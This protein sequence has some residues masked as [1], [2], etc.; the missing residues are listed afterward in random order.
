MRTVL[1][2]LLALLWVSVVFVGTLWL[3]F[4]SDTFAERLRYEVPNTLGPEYSAD[5]KSVAPWWV[6]LSA[7]DLKIYHTAR[8]GEEEAGAVLVALVRDARARVSVWSLLRR[9][10]YLSGSVTLTEGT[11][12]YE[13]GTAADDKGRVALSDLVLS[14][15]ALPVSDLLGL[16]GM[17]D[18]RVDGALQLDVDLHAGADGMKD[19]TGS[20]KLGG[21][22]LVIADFEIPGM[23]NLGMEIPVQELVLMAE[24]KDGKATLQHGAFKSDL[25]TAALTGDVTLRD[26]IERSSID[27]EISITE[28]GDQLKAFEGFLSD[29]KQS[30]GTF[31]YACRGVI[32]R[33]GP[34]SCTA[35]RARGVSSRIPSTDRPTAIPRSPTGVPG[36]AVETDEERERRRE[37]IRERLRQ[38]RE[39]REGG[40]TREVAPTRVDPEPEEDLPEDDEEFLH[41]EEEDLAPEDDPFVEDLEQ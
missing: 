33:L 31:K 23:G 36:G 25:L 4:P 14:A 8:G 40:G 17:G 2:G 3:T 6:G 22:N 32:S 29:A 19:A 9:A 30:D 41:D 16:A 13:V 39:E 26:S 20:L 11:L 21:A 37:E 12:D 1:T 34:T 15:D 35:A 7:Q 27:L 28:L 10:P 24:V 5:V 18:V 38:K